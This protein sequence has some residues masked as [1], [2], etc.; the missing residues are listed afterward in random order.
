M[1]L[2]S[3]IIP[4]VRDHTVSQSALLIQK[5]NQ[6]RKEEEA[7]KIT[8]QEDVIN[9]QQSDNGLSVL[10]NLPLLS[11]TNDSLSAVVTGVSEN[12]GEPENVTPS[13][14]EQAFEKLDGKPKKGAKAGKKSGK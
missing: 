1:C 7:N 13:L 4:G 8:Q 12:S 3:T 14:L 10:F 5:H 6:Q 9:T 2:C 11:L